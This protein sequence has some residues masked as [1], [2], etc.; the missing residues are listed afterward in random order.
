M[1][2]RVRTPRTSSKPGE[3]HLGLPARS[4][5]GSEERGRGEG[6][7]LQKMPR[8]NQIPS[9]IRKVVRWIMDMARGTDR[10]LGITH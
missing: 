6:L 3:T 5:I 8:R 9:M 10:V 4:A 7:C 2:L 1:T